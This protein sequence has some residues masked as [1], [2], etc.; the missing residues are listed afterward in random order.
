M[1]T[2]QREIDVAMVVLRA[3]R[4][5]G[6]LERERRDQR[7]GVAVVVAV[8]AAAASALG[9]RQSAVQTGARRHLLADPFVAAIAAVGGDAGTALVARFALRAAI[10]FGQAGVRRVQRAGARARAADVAPGEEQ[11]DRQRGDRQQ[12]T[13]DSHPRP[14]SSGKTPKSTLP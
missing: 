5:A 10:E 4:D 11:H 8:A 1:R 6:A 12:P 13:S 14:P 7:H 9:H 2:D 3:I